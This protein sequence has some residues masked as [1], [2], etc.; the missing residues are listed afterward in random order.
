MQWQIEL[1][2]LPH[3]FID[4]VILY[5]FA[6]LLLLLLLRVDFFPSTESYLRRQIDINANRQPDILLQDLM[7]SIRATMKM[8]HGTSIHFDRK[9]VF[10]YI[11]NTS[12][13]IDFPVNKIWQAHRKH[14]QCVIHLCCNWTRCF[15]KKKLNN[16]IKWSALTFSIN[17]EDREAMKN[18]ITSTNDNQLK[19]LK[20]QSFWITA[21]INTSKWY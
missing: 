19:T 10:L 8:F 17:I 5:S 7:C 18:K 15:E 4:V 9:T 11:I 16:I 13:R 14:L 1:R 12:Y 2:T 3:T 6:L 21:P 20:A